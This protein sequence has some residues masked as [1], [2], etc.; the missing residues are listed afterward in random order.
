MKYSVSEGASMFGFRHLFDNGLL[1]FILL[2]VLAIFFASVLFSIA[3]CFRPTLAPSSHNFTYVATAI[4][5]LDDG[6]VNN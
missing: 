6:S 5:G 1:G 2:S 3:A 4:A